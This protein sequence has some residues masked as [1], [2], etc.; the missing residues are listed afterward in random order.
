M[1]QSRRATLLFL[2]AGLVVGA[3]ALAPYL[4]MFLTAAKTANEVQA[5]PPTLLPEHWD[6]SNFLTVWTAVPFADYLRSTLIVASGSTVL[7]L[8]VG[9]PA[10][11]Y[12]ARFRFRGRRIYLLLMIMTQVFAPASLVIG[13]FREYIAFGLIDSYAALIITDAA[14]N[15]AFTIWLLH[16]FFASIPPSLEEAALIDGCSTLQALVRVSLPL[17]MPG[18]VT[19]AIYSFIAAWNE[20]VVALTILSTEDKKPLTVGISEFLGQFNVDWPHLFAG[21]LIAIVPV[22]ILFAVIERYLVN[23]LTAGSVK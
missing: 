5:I 13:L 7:V 8:L 22:V 10:A 14:F 20:F 6:F 18:I 3:L 12:L 1:R 16:G 9:I 23:G 21:S 15:A 17:A 4:Q 11:Y 19:A 2:L